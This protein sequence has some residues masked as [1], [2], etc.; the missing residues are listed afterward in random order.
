MAQRL[1]LQP[2]RRNRRDP[3][4]IGDLLDPAA[5]RACRERQREREQPGVLAAHAVRVELQAPQSATAPATRSWVAADA[6][7]GTGV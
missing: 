1:G 5:L 2:A 6:V 3:E 7:R 4:R